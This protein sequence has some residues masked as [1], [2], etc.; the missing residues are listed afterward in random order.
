MLAH[1][2]DRAPGGG[3]YGYGI[4]IARRA[5][6]RP[7]WREIH[8]MSLD[9]KEDYAGFLSFAPH[10]G[11]AV[12][13]SPPAQGS[14]HAAA[15]SHGDEEHS[16]RKTA[17]FIE[18][19]PDGSV[20]RQ[21]EID[22]DVCSCCQTA[23][24]RTRGGWIVAYRDR[25][26]KEIRDISVT[27]FVNGAWTAPQIIHADGWEI[28][29]CPTDGPSLATAGG[30]DVA[31]AWLT[32]AGGT[33]R[34]QAVFSSDQGARFSKPI[35]IDGGNAL[36]RPAITVFDDTSYLVA[37]LE[38]A[39]NGAVDIRLRHL[40]PNGS[41]SQPLV[42]AQA[43]TGRAAGFPKITVSGSQIF[44]AWREERVRAAV[45]HRQHFKK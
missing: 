19:R 14:H 45:L 12:Y 6:D 3:Q 18:F 7:Q 25:S 8:G 22:A 24:G 37:W 29:G 16:H 11:A 40:S 43:P 31:I 38:K 23:I 4:R 44:V 32:R 41:A 10:T 34:I 1:W 27:R 5:A 33:A 15:S 39:A 42:V 9:D 21:Q 36:G 28:N 17:R 2:L 26:P 35:R 30:D 20:A 13:L